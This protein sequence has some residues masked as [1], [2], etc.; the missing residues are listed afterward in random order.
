MNDLVP[1]FGIDG[2]SERLRWAVGAM[3]REVALVEA[4]AIG[5]LGLAAFLLL[6][7]ALFRRSAVAAVSFSFVALAALLVALLFGRF[8]FIS[9]GTQVLIVCLFACSVLL[10]HTATVRLARENTLIG[11]VMLLAIFAM[12]LAGGASMLQFIDGW[13]VARIAIGGTAALTILFLFFEFLR[14]DKGAIAVAPGLLLT[15][16]SL[17]AMSFAAERVTGA[18]WLVASTPIFLLTG[19][20]L[21]A[22]LAAQ[23]TAHTIMAPVP[24]KTREKAPKRAAPLAPAVTVASASAAAA[25][26]GPLL[27]ELEDEP[28]DM[29]RPVRRVSP[30]FDA[31]PEPQREQQAPIRRVRPPEPEIDA[32]P[33]QAPRHMA[34]PVPVPVARDQKDHQATPRDRFGER[35]EPYSAQW[36]HDVQPGYA[37]REIP[38]GDDEY[39]WD[40]MAQREVRMGRGFGEMLRIR[41]GQLATP[42]VIRDLI[43]ERSLPDFDDAILGGYEPQTGRFDIRVQTIDGATIRLEGR[44]QVDQDGLLARLEMQAEALAAAAPQRAEPEPAPQRPTGLAA[45]A[46]PAALAKDDSPLTAK[47]VAGASAALDAGQIGPWFQPIVRLKDRKVV[48]FEALARWELPGG[49]VRDAQDFVDDLIR[50]GR[51]PD[52]ARI[53]INQAAEELANWVKAEPGLGQFVSVNISATDLPKEDV[54]EIV[55]AAVLR[56]DLPPGAL[57]VELTEGK[58]QASHN[59]ALAAA[60]AIRNAGASLAV[61]D[62]GVGYSTLSR[63]SKFHFDIVK[64]DKSLLEDLTTRKKQ[65]SVV[66]AML[67]AAEKSKAPVVAEG[68]EDEETAEMLIELGCDFGQG[69]LFGAAQRIGGEPAD[70]TSGGGRAD[71]ERNLS[72][73]SRPDDLR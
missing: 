44:R 46:A 8:D 14:G 22:A 54:A 23:L 66:R 7:L 16:A 24:R 65:R 13:P 72:P 60:K 68:I 15:V 50:D 40:M 3:P 17:P 58:I 5:G 27:R 31:E 43:D 10:F 62:F 19:G 59:K 2:Y 47:P 33:E 30:T 63:L 38:I 18:G 26:D 69:F 45:V 70:A 71:T 42:D 67:N 48:G 51:G 52:L 36:G 32:E 28:D 11:L 1:A 55:K 9:S 41:G 57:V 53:V 25:H 35:S 21:L 73:R 61:D 4:A 6:I 29:E 34:A 64:L 12:L 39:V 37:V 20:V 56:F 49:E